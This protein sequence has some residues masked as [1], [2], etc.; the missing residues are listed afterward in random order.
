M[1]ESIALVREDGK[2]VT[3]VRADQPE[4]WEPPEGLVAV[5]P[6]Q[7]PA[8]WQMA[9][10]DTPVPPSVTARQIRLWLVTHGV[11]LATVESAIDSIADQATRD[12]VRV[13]W[14]YAPYVERKHPWLVPLAASLGLTEQQVD[15]AF[16]EAAAL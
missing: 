3:F 7:L 16:R 14:E 15:A 6:E 11:S 4:G 13:E 1:S 8:G 9:D 10:D 5:P 2:V 12:S